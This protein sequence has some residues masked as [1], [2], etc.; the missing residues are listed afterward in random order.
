ME[1][2]VIVDNTIQLALF[3]SEM[4]STLA[5]TVAERDFMMNEFHDMA[6]LKI[7]LRN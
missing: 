5:E 2:N 6:L 3:N 7:E 4:A 1:Y